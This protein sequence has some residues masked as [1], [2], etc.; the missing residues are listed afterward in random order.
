MI[1][2]SLEEELRDNGSSLD[3]LLQ[4]LYQNFGLTDTPWD[5]DDILDALEQLVGDNFD[6]ET[7]FN[8]YLLTSQ[9]IPEVNSFELFD[10]D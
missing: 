10:F 7:F 9:E 6:Y 3:A 4:Y 8:T 2:Y 1:A 5:Q